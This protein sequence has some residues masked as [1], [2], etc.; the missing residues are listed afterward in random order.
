MAALSAPKVGSRRAFGWICS[1]WTGW[2]QKNDNELGTDTERQGKMAL[3]TCFG[4]RWGKQ[5][6]LL[7]T[8]VVHP[9]PA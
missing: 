2:D 5:R 9:D 1:F 8:T 4:E 6:L 3:V 7:G